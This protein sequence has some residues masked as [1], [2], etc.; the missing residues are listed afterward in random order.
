[1]KI[2]IIDLLK[3]CVEHDDTLPKK[4]KYMGEEYNLYHNNS[5]FPH[6]YLGLLEQIN[7]FGELNNDVEIIED[8]CECIDKEVEKLFEEDKEIKE[9]I[10]DAQRTEDWNLGQIE[11]RINKL[12][13]AVN[14]L[15]GK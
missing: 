3:R 2:K 12:I 4:I 13:K 15:R 7:E 11:D 1:M 8:R 5:F 6:F 10:L 14:K 9:I